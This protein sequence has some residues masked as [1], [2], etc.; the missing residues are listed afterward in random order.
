MTLPIIQRGSIIFLVGKKVA[1]DTTCKEFMGLWDVRGLL[2][3]ITDNGKLY[4][5]L[6][7]Y[8]PI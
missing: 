7:I 1:M 3:L 4:C 6:D 5:D 2:T 8:M